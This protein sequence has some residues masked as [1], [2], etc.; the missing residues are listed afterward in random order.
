MGP[1]E[2]HFLFLIE[3]WWFVSAKIKALHDMFNPIVASMGFELWGIEYLAQ[4][5]HTLLRVYIDSESGVTIDDCA[6][7]SHQI[8]GLLDVED[9]ISGEYDLEVSSP[10]VDRLLFSLDQYKAFIGHQ[11]QIR[12]RVPF[13]GQ[14]NFKG[15]LNGV[16]GEDVLLIIDE[17][18]LLLPVEMIDRA[19]VV[20]Q[21]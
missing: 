16:E 11:V 7:I 21:F 5:K 10:G 2:A 14:R 19:Q 18:E 4:G 15:L 20:P 3:R 17:E 6:A 9:P 13:E 1:K 12:L 8:S